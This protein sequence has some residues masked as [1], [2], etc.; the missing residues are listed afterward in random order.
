MANK[1]EKMMIIM[2]GRKRFVPDCV[3]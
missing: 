3:T 2:T 1:N